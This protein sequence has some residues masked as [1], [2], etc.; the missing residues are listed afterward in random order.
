[1]PRTSALSAAVLTA[2]LITAGLTVAAPVAAAS[3]APSST[4]AWSARSGQAAP[5]RKAASCFEHYYWLDRPVHCLTGD[6][7]GPTYPNV[8]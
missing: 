6:H 1:M 4:T 5:N 2:A 3:T 8:A 7:N